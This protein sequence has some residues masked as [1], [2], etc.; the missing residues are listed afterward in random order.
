MEQQVNNNTNIKSMN[1]SKYRCLG[2]CIDTKK[3]IEI[4]I[5]IIDDIRN[6][7]ER[8]HIHPDNEVAIDA[9]VDEIIQHFKIIRR[10]VD[11]LSKLF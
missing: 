7:R 4:G 6:S 3:L 2:M 9:K 10:E 8:T 1:Q 5:S 11:E